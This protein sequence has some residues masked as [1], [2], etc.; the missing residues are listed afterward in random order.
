MCDRR[1]LRLSTLKKF[2]HQLWEGK[3]SQYGQRKKTSQ[4]IKYWRG[5]PR[6]KRVTSYKTWVTHDHES[7]NHPV[8]ACRGLPFSVLPMTRLELQ[9]LQQEDYVGKLSFLGHEMV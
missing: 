8:V 5:R 1:D 6:R 2:K 3:R 4:R 9:K 7:V